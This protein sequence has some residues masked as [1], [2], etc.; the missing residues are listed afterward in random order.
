MQLYLVQHGEAKSKEEDPDR[1]LTDNG[2]ADVERVARTVATHD[3]AGPA[4]IIHSGKLRAQQTAEIIAAH[5]RPREGV[6]QSDGLA[7]LDDPAVWLKRLSDEDHDIMLVGH[8]PH[9]DKLAAALLTG[10]SDVSV[11]SFQ[12]GG[13]ICLVRDDSGK[14]RVAWMITPQTLK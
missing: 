7:P 10:N 1:S 5:L 4:R 12:M 14:W 3:A 9:L 11:V 13:I 2:R 8:L 6:S